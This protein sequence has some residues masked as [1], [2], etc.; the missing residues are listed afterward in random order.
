MKSNSTKTKP[1]DALA[2][3]SDD[4]LAQFGTLRETLSATHAEIP[5]LLSRERTITHDLGLA[6]ARG[7]S[8]VDELRAQLD[9]VVH[10]RQASVRRRS[11]SVQG[12]LE[13]EPLLRADRAAAETERQKLAAEVTHEFGQRWQQ[14]CNA[15][16][17]LRSEAAVLSAALRTTIA[18]PAPYVPSVHVV[19]GGLTVNPVAGP[20]PPPVALPGHLSTLVTRLD[21]LDHGL[22]RV[23]AIRQSKQFDLRH[24]DLSKIRGAPA[25]FSGVFLVTGE[26]D[27]LVDGMK[28]APGTLIDATLIGPGQLARLTVARRYLR[29]ADLHTGAAA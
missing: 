27:S 14:A 9:G 20:E 11:A 6:E 7:D 16:A 23:S 2:P 13:L 12:L 22:A 1:E 5:S 19:T 10:E 4:V 24:Y 17:I 15:L 26:F 8:A 25:E 18:C 3:A 29:P 21:A 28:F